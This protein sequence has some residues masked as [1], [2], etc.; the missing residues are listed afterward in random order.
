MK[1]FILLL[2]VLFFIGCKKENVIDIPN[3]ISPN[4]DGINDTWIIPISNAKVSIYNRSG[5]LIFSSNNYQNNFSGIGIAET[6]YYTINDNYSGSITI[7][8]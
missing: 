3:A 1:N 6:V 7:I 2:S 4:G 8:I 5:S